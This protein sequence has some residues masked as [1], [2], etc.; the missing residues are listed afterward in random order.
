[1]F[2][3]KF[4]YLFFYLLLSSSIL[5]CYMAGTLASIEI[6]FAKYFS[7]YA[8]PYGTP[9]LSSRPLLIFLQLILS[10]IWS[11]ISISLTVLAASSVSQT[12]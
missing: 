5:F 7:A 4:V 11:L 10:S 12:H 2:F 6:A 9:H 8:L 1:M 3:F